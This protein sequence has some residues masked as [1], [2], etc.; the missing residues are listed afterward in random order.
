M[1]DVRKGREGYRM[2]SHGWSKDVGDEV[3]SC[4]LLIERNFHRTLLSGLF[5]PF[6]R[7]LSVVKLDG[8]AT[9]LVDP[10]PFAWTSRLRAVRGMETPEGWRRSPSCVGG[11]GRPPTSFPWSRGIREAHVS[12]GARKLP[13][14]MR[15]RP[16]VFPRRVPSA[17]RY[18]STLASDFQWMNL[19][20]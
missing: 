15:R 12:R 10:S 5:D 4:C 17:A 11:R 8:S 9:M 16:I 3:G 14:R 18:Q 20:I 2:M 7:P 13:P 1:A 6:L 19:G